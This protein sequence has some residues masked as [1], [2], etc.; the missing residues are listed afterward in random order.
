MN[1]YK[2]DV[3]GQTVGEY[4]TELEAQYALTV[5]HDLM[6]MSSMQIKPL[7]SRRKDD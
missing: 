4:E 6:P 7:E 5:L 3:E 1:S 2:I